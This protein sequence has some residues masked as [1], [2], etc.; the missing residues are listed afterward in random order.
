M[1]PP[2]ALEDNRAPMVGGRTAGEQAARGMQ[3]FARDLA[4]VKAAF[5]PAPWRRK[6]RRLNVPII[7]SP[8][9]S[10]GVATK[11]KHNEQRNWPP[12]ERK[13]SKAQ[14][15]AGALLM[16][17][18]TK[19]EETLLNLCFAPERGKPTDRHVRAKQRRIQRRARQVQKVSPAR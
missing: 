9:K 12:Q 10:Q 18:P 4:A 1:P 14:D 15:Q 11:A 2:I 13:A 5:K 17:E 6:F 16:L 8:N 3:G 19:F 7:L